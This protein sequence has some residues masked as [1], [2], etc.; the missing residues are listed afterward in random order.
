LEHAATALS[1]CRVTRTVWGAEGVLAREIQGDRPSDPIQGLVSG[2]LDPY[3]KTQSRRY[4][5]HLAELGKSPQPTRVI[6]IAG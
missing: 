6:M 2:V 3:R 5:N 1:N 4:W